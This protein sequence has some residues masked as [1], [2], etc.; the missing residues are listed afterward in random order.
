MNASN[1]EICATVIFFFAIIHTFL[2][3]KFAQIATRYREGSIGENFFHYLAEIEAVFGIWSILFLII[4]IFQIGYNESIHYV[5]S[6]NFT[7]P[8]FV[9]VIMTMA[10]TRSVVN[11]AENL[12]IKSINLDRTLP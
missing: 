6:L 7:E 5:E 3:S 12:I 4:M 2:V 8:A 11:L 1:L 9:F 10:A